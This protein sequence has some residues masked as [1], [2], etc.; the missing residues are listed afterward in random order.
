MW[1][2]NEVETSDNNVKFQIQKKGKLISN[3][4]FLDLLKDS[5]D[6]QK[7][8]ND[9]L[10]S[11]GFEAF[12]WE[13]KPITK[14]TLES[15]Y[16]CN[17]VKSDFLAGVA[18]DNK[19]FNQYFRDDKPVVSFPNLGNDAQLVAPCPVKKYSVYTHIGNFVRRADDR[20][21]HEFWKKVG[22]ETLKQIGSKP[23]W[24]S[25]SGLGVFWLHVRIDTY[26]KYYQTNEYKFL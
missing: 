23:K 5:K 26:P 13:N 3:K 24:L 1:T 19:S 18:P 6:F 11:S 22:Q 20:Q 10:A 16:E 4:Q 17:L 21:L 12:F 2:I 15:A 9:Y 7:F 8:Y 14:Q 25:T